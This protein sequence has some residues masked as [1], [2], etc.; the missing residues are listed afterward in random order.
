MKNKVDNARRMRS[1]E[2]NPAGLLLL[3]R[4]SFF[5]ISMAI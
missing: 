4:Q 1:I 5:T 3:P 2:E